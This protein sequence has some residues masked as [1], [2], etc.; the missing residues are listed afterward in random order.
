MSWEDCVCWL[1]MEAMTKTI[2]VGDAKDWRDYPDE[3]NPSR[4]LRGDIA[5]E[6]LKQNETWLSDI[7]VPIYDN[8]LE[9]VAMMFDA[10]SASKVNEL[11]TNIIWNYIKHAAHEWLIDCEERS[12][13]W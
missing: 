4:E 11:T 12:V 1:D 9:W 10:D 3:F 13:A 8:Q 5:L 6:F 2:Y 7:A